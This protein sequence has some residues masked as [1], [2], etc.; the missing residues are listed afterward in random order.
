MSKGSFAG[1]ILSLCVVFSIFTP[2][3]TGSFAF[4]FGESIGISLGMVALGVVTGTILWLPVR[5]VK[6]PEKSPDLKIF[7]VVGTLI[8]AT[9]LL[10]GAWRHYLISGG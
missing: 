6:G 1:V 4:W 10:I 8:A 2:R 3:R 9:V 7:V 5:A